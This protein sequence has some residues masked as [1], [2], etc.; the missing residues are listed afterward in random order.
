[1]A[2]LEVALLSCHSQNLQ[3]AGVFERWI[4]SLELLLPLSLPYHCYPRNENNSSTF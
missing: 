4:G 2:L 3:Y 1:M